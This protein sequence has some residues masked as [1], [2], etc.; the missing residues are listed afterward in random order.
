[1]HSVDVVVLFGRPDQGAENS[2]LRAKWRGQ[3]LWAIA[4]RRAAQTCGRGRTVQAP[5]KCA[6]YTVGSRGYQV[7]Q[8]LVGARIERADTV[9][10]EIGS[11]SPHCKSSAPSAEMREVCRHQQGE[12]VRRMPQRGYSAGL[13]LCIIGPVA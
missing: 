1:M 10:S 11:S 7:E 8:R 6:G 3:L 9:R 12:G 2:C 13:L 4:G 5:Q